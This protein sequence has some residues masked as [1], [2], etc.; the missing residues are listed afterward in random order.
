MYR[1]RTWLHRSPRR[2][3]CC[4]LL[5]MGIAVGTTPVHGQEAGY[6]P[7]KSPYQDLESPQRIFLFGGYFAAGKD[8]IGAAPQ[9]APL[10]G[11]QYEVSIGGPAQFFVRAARASSKRDTF[12]PSQPK[13]TRSLGTIGDPLWLVDLGFLFDLTGQKSWHHLVPT[14]AFGVGLANARASTADDPYS[15]G[16]Q[17]AFNTDLGIRYVPGNTYDVRLGIGNTF[18]QNHYPTGYYVAT[19]D[20]TS[21]IGNGIAKTSYLNSWRLTAGLSVPL[22]R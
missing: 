22:F 21:L 20:G 12:D 13:A 16:T 3:L 15:F 2:P 17:F 19:S 11:A 4:A 8:R 9:S 1:L 7:S 18:Y 6:P 5:G 14:F 10:F